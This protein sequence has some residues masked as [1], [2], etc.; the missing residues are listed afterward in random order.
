[1]FLLISHD[2]A[3]NEKRIEKRSARS[4]QV[5]LVFYSKK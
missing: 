3:G 5:K 4:L 1:M 2:K